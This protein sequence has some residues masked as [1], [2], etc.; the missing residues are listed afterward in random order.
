MTT[1]TKANLNEFNSC[2]STKGHSAANRL[3][4]S[5]LSDDV[6][7][8]EL[9]DDMVKQTAPLFFNSNA[10]KSDRA[11]TDLR[12]FD[13]LDGPR[14]YYQ[15]AVLL[16]HPK[17]VEAALTC[18][19]A[20]TRGRPASEKQQVENQLEY[21]NSPYRGLGG[22]FMLALDMPT[23]HDYQRSYA[24][25]LLRGITAEQYDAIATMAFKA[26]ALVPL[27]QHDFDLASMAEMIAARYV[28]SI[29]GFAQKD[30]GLIL[31]STRKIGR[32]L[33][34]QI[35][36]RHFVF[37]PST[38]IECRTG[39]A[40]LAQRATEIIELFAPSATLTRVQQDEKDEIQEDIDRLGR[41]KFQIDEKGTLKQSL[42]APKAPGCPGFIPLLQRMASEK[43]LSGATQEFGNVEKGLIAAS[44]VG[45]S[46]TNIQNSIC[47]C[48]A[49]I[50][51]QSQQDLIKIRRQ[52][53]DERK[54]NPDA[55]WLPDT[56]KTVDWVKEALRVSPPVVF[57]PRRTN[58]DVQLNSQPT[59]SAS[60][61]ACSHQTTIPKDTL[62]LVAL[63]GTSCYGYQA[64]NPDFQLSF[65]QP[66]NHIDSDQQANCPF[67]K[68]MGGAPNTPKSAGV[69]AHQPRWQYTHSCP[70][71]MMA[72]YVIA[73]TVRQLLVLPSLA[74]RIN[75]DTG[76]PYGL[77]KRWGFQCT[78]YPLSYQKEQLLK[79][80]PLQT[81][82]PVRTPIDFHSQELRKVIATGA[83]FI[84]KV[85]ADSKMV[86]FAS[87]V[88]LDNDSKLALFT[89]YDGDFDTYIGLF[90]K[91][92]GHLFDRF[93]EHVAISP[94]MP[95][96]EHPFEFV[97]YLKQ[98]VLE[99]VGGYYFSA[100]PEAETDR[101]VQQN[102][103]QYDFNEI[104]GG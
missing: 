36:G 67:S 74:Q 75:A 60:G 77:E 99:P 94:K 57:V 15:D 23:E 42:A 69:D 64:S 78:S 83:P 104:R 33:Q 88:F 8:R 73:Y 3:L 6:L 91:E 45:G 84:D 81:I 92:F 48:L 101:I 13:W 9:I 63:A 85:I 43:A 11:E 38:M 18:S 59:G 56:S 41:Y 7:R 51:K 100:Y 1:P 26:G 79:Q 24:L 22:Y 65:D 4:F 16:A 61:Y 55:Q 44:L 76:K 28:L 10:S 66:I 68:I 82:L 29:F 19:N 103:R 25:E 20:L 102:T 72:M 71:M 87:F 31:E 37:E 70:G 52:A 34:Y 62:V 35:M 2:V 80:T 32:G 30:I 50:F 98:F 49:E 40:K 93:F 12:D 47:I 27:R 17:H 96:R 90:A 53:I 21:S 58:K 54:K 39:L 89:M 95:I 86:H 97:Q 46:V 14:D 5:W